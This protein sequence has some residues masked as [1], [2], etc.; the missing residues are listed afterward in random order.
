[1]TDQPHRVTWF[2]PDRP[3]EGCTINIKPEPEP[4]LVDGRYC[5]DHGIDLVPPDRTLRTRRYCP[6]CP[7]GSALGFPTDPKESTS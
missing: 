2:H 4:S 1:M 6:Q 3:V 7:E 5:P